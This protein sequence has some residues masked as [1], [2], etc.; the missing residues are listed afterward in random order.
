MS[1]GDT[2]LKRSS[3]TN[4]VTASLQEILNKHIYNITIEIMYICL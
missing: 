2:T 1:V 4:K 3:C